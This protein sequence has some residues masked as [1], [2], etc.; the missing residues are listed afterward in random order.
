M[1]AR[2]RKVG[3][4]WEMEQKRELLARIEDALADAEEKVR[5]PSAKYPL[6]PQQALEWR[7]YCAWAASKVRA[8]LARLEALH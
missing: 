6:T 7:D 3:D 2:M 5:H 1:M 8:D 4:S